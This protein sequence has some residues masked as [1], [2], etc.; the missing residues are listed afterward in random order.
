MAYN[1]EEFAG[2]NRQHISI[3]ICLQLQPIGTLVHI[4]IHSSKS[5]IVVVVV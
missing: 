1:C 3:S 5:A 2:E 4:W